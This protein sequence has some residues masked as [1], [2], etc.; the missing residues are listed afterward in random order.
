MQDQTKMYNI[1]DRQ[2]TRKPLYLLGFLAFYRVITLI[3]IL[4]GH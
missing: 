4:M 3:Y 2:K 1:V